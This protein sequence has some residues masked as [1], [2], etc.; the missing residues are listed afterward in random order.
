MYDDEVH[1][2]TEIRTT[3]NLD[4]FDFVRQ[5][6]D[7]NLVT[8]DGALIQLRRMLFVPAE[9]HLVLQAGQTIELYD[10]ASIVCRSDIEVNGTEEAPVKLT[11]P[12]GSGHG[13]LVLE[14][15]KKDARSPINWLIC[16]GLNEIHSG[17]Y[18]LTGCVTFY[19]SDV[20]INNCKFLNNGSEDGLNIVRSDFAVTN[21]RFYNTFQDAFDA[22]FCTGY[23]D[24]VDFELTGNDAFDV[25][26]SDVRVLNCTFKDIHDK[27]CSIGEASTAYIENI[28]VVN[29]Q[30]II[31]AKDNSNVTA[32]NITGKNIFIGYV[33]YQK[34]PEFGHSR[35]E[36]ENMTFTGKYDFDYLIEKDEEYF[37]DGKQKLPRAKKKEA[38]IIDRLINEVPIT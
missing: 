8:F 22:D 37:L 13:L 9:K 32:K 24:H 17:I 36:I 23:F 18:G 31:G 16:D 21:S 7:S 28:A 12:D 33:A 14:G 10:G 15:N 6:E 19:E 29:A 20:D 38:L 26:T 4:E 11:A 35:A 30:A 1:F 3:D 34:K 5:S 2:G 25:S 27:A